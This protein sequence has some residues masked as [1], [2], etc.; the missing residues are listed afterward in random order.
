M[1]LKKRL[2]ILPSTTSKNFP[3]RLK[4]IRLNQGLTLAQLAKEAGISTVMPGRYER[5]ESLPSKGTW[6]KL[7]KAL[8][9]KEIYE[10]DEIDIA[11]DKLGDFEED[12]YDEDDD[13]DEEDDYDEDDYSDEDDMD[14]DDDDKGNYLKNFS[15]EDLSKELKKRG[16]K[17]SLFFK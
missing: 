13:N 4:R 8:F 1:R 2:N 15:V 5:G 17:V 3:K 12:D 7:K 6:D 14:F 11:L 16:F 10:P 9:P